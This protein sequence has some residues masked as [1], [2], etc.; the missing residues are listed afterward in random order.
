MD[1]VSTISFYMRSIFISID[2]I[3]LHFIFN[4][5]YSFKPTK[6]TRIVWIDSEWVE[7]RK[8]YSFY[9]IHIQIHKWNSYWIGSN[10]NI[11]H[12]HLITSNI[13]NLF[14]QSHQQFRNRDHTY[15]NSIINHDSIEIM[16]SQMEEEQNSI[17]YPISYQLDR[18]QFN[19]TQYSKKSI[20]YNNTFSLPLEEHLNTIFN[21]HIITLISIEKDEYND[22]SSYRE[23]TIENEGIIK[24]NHKR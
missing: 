21:Q 7:S 10:R 18:K 20:K 4:H 3:T 23:N 17:N 12:N 16:S 24:W 14:I 13:I 2:T 11:H 6:M 5:I 9:S 22:Y 8:H 15:L 19:I 1:S